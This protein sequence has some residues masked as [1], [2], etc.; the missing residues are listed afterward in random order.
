[1]E[2]ER[3]DMNEREDKDVGKAW[4]TNSRIKIRTIICSLDKERMS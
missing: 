3:Q 1:M 4:K 2:K